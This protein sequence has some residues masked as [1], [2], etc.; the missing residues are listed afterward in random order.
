MKGVY[1][2]HL[3]TKMSHAQHYCGYADDIAARVARHQ[4]GRGARMLQ[5]ARERGIKFTLALT[6]PGWTRSQ[7]RMLKR[8]KQA[9]HYC[10]LCNQQAPLPSPVAGHTYRKEDPRW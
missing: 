10:P 9:P 3:D 1:I 2:I 4:A 7:E 8:R 6:L 5:V